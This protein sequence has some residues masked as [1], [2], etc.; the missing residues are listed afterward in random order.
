MFDPMMAMNLGMMN[1]LPFQMM[2]RQSGM[3]RFMPMSMQQLQQQQQ[4]QQQRSTTLPFENQKPRSGY[5]CFKCGEPGHW[6]YYCPNVPKGQYVNRFNSAANPGA[7]TQMNELDSIP[8]ELTCSICKKLFKNASMSLCCGK[9]F[10]EDCITT[11]LNDKQQCPVCDKEGLTTDQIIPNK[12]LRNIVNAFQEERKMAEE[13]IQTNQRDNQ[14]IDKDANGSDVQ[15]NTPDLK[16]ETATS[17]PDSSAEENQKQNIN[18]P[19]QSQQQLKQYQQQQQQKLPLPQKQQQASDSNDNRNPSHVRKNRNYNMEGSH[20]MDSMGRGFNNMPTSGMPFMS[21]PSFFMGGNTGMPP[22]GFPDMSWMFAGNSGA[23]RGH[24]PSG[25]NVPYFPSNTGAP[26]HFRGGFSGR[27]RGTGRGRALNNNNNNQQ[28]QQHQQQSSSSQHQQKSPS[29]P[30]S[31]HSEQQKTESSQ[32]DD[33]FNDQYSYND[34]D[35]AMHDRIGSPERYRSRQQNV[36]DKRSVTSNNDHYESTKH[37]HRSPSDTR[38]SSH[39]HHVHKKR[40]RSRSPSADRKRKHSSSSRK[41]HRSS[42]SPKSSHYSD[43]DE[44]EDHHHRRHSRRRSR[45]SRRHRES[46]SSNK[47]RSSSR[48]HHSDEHRRKDRNRDPSRDRSHRERK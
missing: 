21:N 23:G 32:R 37:R 31:H 47:Y 41:Y 17:V 40:S 9:S 8:D 15:D 25:N 19:N 6:I 11:A 22:F 18:K 34:N 44:E 20:G 7:M 43:D 39:H 1:S 2:I 46:S 5:I 4:S 48:H 45:S 33:D 12:T 14:Q 30:S 13:S 27:G 26:I 16:D 28:Q 38:S 29:S 10:C 24:F 35:E 3:S 36:E 42:G